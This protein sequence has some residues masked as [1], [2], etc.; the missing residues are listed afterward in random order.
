MFRAGY[1]ATKGINETNYTNF[2]ICGLQTHL[3]N[4]DYRACIQKETFASF[5]NLLRTSQFP[6]SARSGSTYFH[7]PPARANTL[8]A[9][10]FFSACSLERT[11]LPRWRFCRRRWN[12]EA[13]LSQCLYVVLKKGI[14]IGEQRLVTLKSIL[15]VADAGMRRGEPAPAASSLGRMH[16]WSAGAMGA[17]QQP[18]DRRTCRKTQTKEGMVSLGGTTLVNSAVR[19]LLTAQSSPDCR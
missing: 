18:V 7:R 16:L 3:H 8:L 5:G 9:R 17:G 2:I 14:H 19:G 4:T 15:E 13:L 12:W 10:R 11:A 6:R 1:A